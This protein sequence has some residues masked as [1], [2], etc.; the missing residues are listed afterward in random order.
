MHLSEIQK[1]HMTH[2]VIKT[3]SSEPKAKI[4][5]TECTWGKKT[6]LF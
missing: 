5:V 2:Y 6:K 3:I 1:Q 4:A